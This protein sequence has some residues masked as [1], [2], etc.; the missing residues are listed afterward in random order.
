MY[1]D[2]LGT[3]DLSLPRADC[4]QRQLQCFS[5]RRSSKCCSASSDCLF[6]QHSVSSVLHTDSSPGPFLFINLLSVC[7]CLIS[8]VLRGVSGQLLGII[9]PTS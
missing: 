8:K 6:F 2:G 3:Q 7:N 5:L 9:S 1:L 4:S